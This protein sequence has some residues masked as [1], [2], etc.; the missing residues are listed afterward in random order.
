[1]PA[2]VCGDD[3]PVLPVDPDSGGATVDGQ[4]GIGRRG[5]GEGGQAIP[6]GDDLAEEDPVVGLAVLGT[7]DGDAEA[8]GPV[9]GEEVLD[10]TGADHA[11]ADDD[12]ARHALTPIGLRGQ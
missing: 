9:L 12:D 5:K 3:D 4:A 11:V 7:E 1:M 8:A 2:A 10:E 6:A